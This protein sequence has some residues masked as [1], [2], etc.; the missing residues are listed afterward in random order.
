MLLVLTP[1]P[2][3]PY[4]QNRRRESSNRDETN[5]YTLCAE[6][7]AMNVI[8]MLIRARRGWRNEGRCG[9]L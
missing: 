8:A 3:V 4:I 5:L 1:Y 2:T 6:S 7:Y 9:N